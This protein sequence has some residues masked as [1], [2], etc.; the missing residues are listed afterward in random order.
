M[1]GHTLTADVR[2]DE[3]AI[4]EFQTGMRGDVLRPDDAGYDEARRLWNG[5]FDRRP[6][7]IARCTGA[8]DVMAAVNFARENRL[9]IAV[10][11]GGHSLPGQSVC[12]GGLMIDLSPM[13]SV[14]VD[15]SKRT[16]RAGGGCLWGAV[17]HETAAF[18][19]ATVGGTVSHTGIGGLTL[20]G[21]F[22]WL[23]RKYG[24]VV[25]NLLSVDIVTADGRFLTAS[26]DEN[27]DLF[28]GVRGGGGNFG[29]VTSFEYR[30]H[31]V[32]P[33]VVGGMALF[34]AARAAEVLRAYREI[35]A[36]APDELTLAAVYISAPP[37][38]FV[39]A[40]AVG[41]PMLAIAGCYAG[42]IEDGQR[43]MEPVR[44]LRPIVDLLGPMPYTALQTIID[45]ANP[46]GLQYYNKSH[47]HADLSDDLIDTFA[48]QAAGKTS[49]T[50]YLLLFP[51]GG[52]TA[53]SEGGDTAMG[54]RDTA[55]IFVL[56]SSWVDPSESERH[57][58]WTRDVWAA[59]QPFATGA[60]YV[61][62]LNDDPPDKVSTAYEPATFRRL[63]EVKTK[64]DP[65]NVFRFNQ[66][67]KP[68]SSTPGG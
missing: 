33:I 2:L 49:P 28:W 47:Y 21:G 45:E 66:N 7:V 11:G 35:M 64:Y 68:R 22:G 41:A 8:A 46:H 20:G 51:F 36:A 34:P 18:G 23:G 37:A 31:E 38:P 10:R 30:L 48:A 4:Q 26:A 32:G 5:M 67:V 9:A 52:A 65:T 19:L 17:D 50:S 63:I 3:K 12:D 29:V 25:D 27:P 14:R 57:I 53:R 44:A 55:Y 16:V 24:F 56:I 40:D 6:A 1:V 59:L 60:I 43:A 54:N 42:S 58:G 39:P 62:D 15:P 61:N 13:N